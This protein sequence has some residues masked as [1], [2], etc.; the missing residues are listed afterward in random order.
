MLS[1]NQHEAAP[2]SSR[3]QQSAGPITETLNTEAELKR[4]VQ[5]DNARRQRETNRE[6]A[7]WGMKLLYKLSGSEALKRDEAEA[8]R[9]RQAGEETAE[10][11]ARYKRERAETRKELERQLLEHEASEEQLP[12]GHGGQYGEDLPPPFHYRTKGQ[13]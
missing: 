12:A 6:N 4:Q 1:K 9:V 7:P 8:L 10:D 13:K 3:V 2:S 11:K 5:A